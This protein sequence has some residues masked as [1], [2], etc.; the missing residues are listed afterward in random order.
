MAYSERNNFM[1]KYGRIEHVRDFINNLHKGGSH[2]DSMAAEHALHRIGNETNKKNGML[3]TISKSPEYMASVGKVLHAIHK[4]GS[5]DT[6]SNFMRD[7]KGEINTEQLRTVW[8]E[9]HGGSMNGEVAP[10]IKH[11][12]LAHPNVPPSILRDAMGHDDSFLRQSAVAHQ[13]SPPDVVRMGLQDSSDHVEKEARRVA[14]S[15]KIPL[16]ATNG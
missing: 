15:R 12:V 2:Y 9:P 16:K 6:L 10:R 13:N 5:V 14:K 1:M 8:T 4:H 3:G 7:H 11:A